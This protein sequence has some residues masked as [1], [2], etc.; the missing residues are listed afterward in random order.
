MSLRDNIAFAVDKAGRVHVFLAGTYYLGLV[1]TD[2]K[3]SPSI[4]KVPDTPVVLLHKEMPVQSQCVSDIIPSTLYFPMLVQEDI[5]RIAQ[6][7]SSLRDLL[8]Y[9]SSVLETMHRAWFLGDSPRTMG[10]LWLV[11]LENIQTT[12]WGCKYLSALR[13]NILNILRFRRARHI[14]ALHPPRSWSPI[15]SLGCSFKRGRKYE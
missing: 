1:Q 11:A 9:C 12:G 2:F 15:A 7:S 6:I 5:H 14:G 3:F 13:Y 8:G 10:K 4:F